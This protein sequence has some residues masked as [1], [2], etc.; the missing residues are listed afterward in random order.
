MDDYKLVQ[1]DWEDSC[2][3]NG[4]VSQ[5]QAKCHRP[6][7]C[8]TVGFLLRSGKRDMTIMQSTSNTGNVSEIMAIPRGCIKKVTYLKG[9]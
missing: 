6:A 4:W 2:S 3:D 9:E 7:Q 5:Q 1:I 8:R